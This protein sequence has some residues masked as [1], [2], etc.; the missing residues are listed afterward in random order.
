M[1]APTS[2]DR[3]RSWSWIG[4][5]IPRRLYVGIAL[6]TFA[7]L[8]VTWVLATATGVVRPLFLPSPV[9]V[10]E[11]LKLAVTS[12]ILA[13]DLLDSSLRIIGGFALA[14]VMSIPIG[15]LAGAFRVWESAVEPLVNFVRYMPV[16]AFVPL[17]IMWAG[18]GELQKYLIIW[19]GTFFQQVL[20]V[21]DDVKRVPE[22]FV[23]LGRILGLPERRIIARIVLPWAAPAI[24]DTLRITL[25]WAW[26]W[27][28]LAELVAAASGLGYRITVAQRFFETDLILAYILIL[29]IVGLMIDQGIKIAG[30]RMFAWTEVAR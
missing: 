19:I 5:P 30:K 14:T 27:L 6:G 10:L 26:T 22:E 11:R 25:G 1:A 29:G 18:I 7:A 24:W 9:D 28:I 15:I 21:M 23:N 3:R 12:G 20:L 16:V 17:T 2:P 8:L 13:R 4:Q